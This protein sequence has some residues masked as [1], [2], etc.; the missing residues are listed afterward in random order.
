MI[1]RHTVDVRQGT[2]FASQE[3]DSSVSTLQSPSLVNKTALLRVV[4]SARR[5]RWARR[6]GGAEHLR[7]ALD[8]DG[9]RR[10]L[11]RATAATS[12]PASLPTTRLPAVPAS[13]RATCSSGS[14]RSSCSGPTTSSSRCTRPDRWI[15]PRIRHRPTGRFRAPGRF[16][17]PGFRRARHWLYLVARRA[18]VYSRCSS[19]RAF[20]F[21]GRRTRRRCI[22]SGCRVAFFGVLTFS[23]SGRLDLLDWVFYWGDVVAMLLL[24]PL[25]V[26]FALV[27]PERPDNWARS[28]RGAD[29]AAAALSAGAAARRRQRRGD[30][31][32]RPA[33]RDPHERRHARRSRG[34]R[35]T[36]RSVSSAGSSS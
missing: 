33:R 16:Q 4:G 27:F 10:F 2:S 31:S 6:P 23:F 19:A 9:G 25:F 8:G 29:A 11:G 12:S 35:S 32:R 5:G 13:S 14:T 17:L 1:Y 24:P 26:H 28:E 36:W 30:P 22:S 7:Q 34:A 3:P 15:P 20:G 18:S 21:A